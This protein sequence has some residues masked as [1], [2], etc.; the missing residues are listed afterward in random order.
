MDRRGPP[1]TPLRAPP[2]ERDLYSESRARHG[3][4]Y[5]EVSRLL[6]QTTTRHPQCRE[7]KN[8]SGRTHRKNEEV[9]KPEKSTSPVQH[10]TTVLRA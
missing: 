3:T 8:G 5:L 2:R 9:L 10:A 4:A 1:P 7:D 6:V